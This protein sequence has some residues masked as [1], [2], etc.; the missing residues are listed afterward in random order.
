MYTT[1]G[2]ERRRSRDPGEH[3]GVF[4]QGS[5][6][7]TGVGALALGHALPVGARYHLAVEA[8]YDVHWFTTPALRDEG[9]TSAR[10]VHRVQSKETTRQ[11]IA[12]ATAT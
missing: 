6:P 7:I 5:G 3:S 4:R 2:S 11:V 10:A 8:R 9:F 12:E 1:F